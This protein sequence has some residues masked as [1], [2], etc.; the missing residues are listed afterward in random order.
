M[1]LVQIRLLISTKCEIHEVGDS[2]THLAM[3]MGILFSD[4]KTAYFFLL[5]CFKKWKTYKRKKQD[6]GPS[7]FLR[8]CQN[9][10]SIESLFL[11]CDGSW[12]TNFA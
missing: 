5:H 8:E 6:Q 1:L 11:L 9:H 10:L 4:L 12:S 2:I 3:E 7:V